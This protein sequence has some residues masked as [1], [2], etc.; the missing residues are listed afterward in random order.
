MTGSPDGA[1]LAATRRDHEMTRHARRIAAVD[2][3]AVVLADG[4]LLVLT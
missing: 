2:R 3:G 4:L 1:I